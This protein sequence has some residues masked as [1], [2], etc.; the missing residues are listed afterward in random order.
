MTQDCVL[1][2]APNTT[3]CVY[4]PYDVHVVHKHI[5]MI[6]TGVNVQCMV[7]SALATHGSTVSFPGVS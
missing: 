2:E 7:V 5:Q 1:L 3:P 4:I 6:Y